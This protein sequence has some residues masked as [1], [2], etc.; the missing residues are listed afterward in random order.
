MKRGNGEV[1]EFKYLET[2]SSKHWEMEGEINEKAV[3]C[4][5]IIGVLA[6]SMKGG[7]CPW[8]RRES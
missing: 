4:R 7:M 6:R 5:S 8:R 3:K 2:M 1:K